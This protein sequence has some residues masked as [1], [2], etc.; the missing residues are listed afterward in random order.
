MAT[1]RAPE[2]KWLQSRRVEGFEEGGVWRFGGL[3]LEWLGGRGNTRGGKSEGVGMVGGDRGVWIEMGV[4]VHL[5]HLV[6]NPK[7]SIMK[8]PPPGR[9]RREI[10]VDTE[11]KTTSLKKK[12]IEKMA[13]LQLV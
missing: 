12:K 6:F 10:K 11:Y 8:G 2:R 13:S 5:A 3:G 4:F 1:G 9:V 7:I